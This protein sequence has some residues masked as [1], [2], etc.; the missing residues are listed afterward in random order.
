[1]QILFFC[2]TMIRS[3]WV[4]ISIKNTHKNKKLEIV[5]QIIIIRQDV[6]IL[7]NT[8]GVFFAK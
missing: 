2:S 5:K 4:K 3:E 6:D 7:T 8:L 1:M